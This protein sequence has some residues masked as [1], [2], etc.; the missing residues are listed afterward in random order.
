MQKTVDGYSKI[1]LDNLKVKATY[2]RGISGVPSQNTKSGSFKISLHS[3]L[4]EQLTKCE[5][6]IV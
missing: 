4:E 1:A 5:V 2:F 3:D 6:S